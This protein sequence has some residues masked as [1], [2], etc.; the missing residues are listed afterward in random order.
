MRNAVYHG[1]WVSAA[2]K[3]F[4]KNGCPAYAIASDYMTGSAIRQ[5][6]LQTAIEWINDGKVDEY[7][8]DHQHDTNANELWLY[9]KGSSTGS[10]R[11]SRRRA[12]T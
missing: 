7:M 5:E 1:P 6:Y 9:F 2:K 11:P 3:Y 8:R 12:R 10:R 4:S